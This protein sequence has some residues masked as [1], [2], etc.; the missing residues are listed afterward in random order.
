MNLDLFCSGGCWCSWTP[1]P[2][3]KKRGTGTTG[4]W[5]GKAGIIMCAVPQC[6]TTYSSGWLTVFS[7]GILDLLEPQG[8]QGKRDLLVPRYVPRNS[9]L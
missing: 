7:R 5:A 8:S 1:R 9:H 3:W 4:V 2:P 6:V